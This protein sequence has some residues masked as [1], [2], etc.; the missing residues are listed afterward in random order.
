MPEAEYELH[1]S[2]FDEANNTAIFFATCHAKHTDEGGP[3]PPTGKETHSQYVYAV[4]MDDAGK[5]S[6][7][8]KIWNPTWA[9]SELGWT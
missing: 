9:L 8:T 5:V 1:A 6:K 3:V 2:A 4:T 7:M